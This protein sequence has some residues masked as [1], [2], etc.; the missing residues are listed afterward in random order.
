[1]D[2][3]I[4]SAEESGV[5]GDEEHNPLAQYEDLTV[6]KQAEIATKQVVWLLLFVVFNESLKLL[7]YLTEEDISTTST[8][9]ML[10]LSIARI[11]N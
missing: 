5:A 9:C 6:T 4:T 10:L 1:M 3:V 11:P 7:V 2:V 8:I